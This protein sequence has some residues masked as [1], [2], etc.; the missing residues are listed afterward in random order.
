MG[1]EPNLTSV[2]EAARHFRCSRQAIYRALDEQRLTEVRIGNGRLVAL[3]R[4]YHA[5][6]A[7]PYADKRQEESHQLDEE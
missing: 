5:F 2:N 6:K 7:R 1:K 4:N 3:D